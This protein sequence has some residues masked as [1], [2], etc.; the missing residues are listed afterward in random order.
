[1]C[2]KIHSFIVET[3]LPMLHLLKLALCCSNKE[4]TVPVLKELRIY[5]LTRKAPGS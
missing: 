4:H 1:M 3:L 5:S 2:S